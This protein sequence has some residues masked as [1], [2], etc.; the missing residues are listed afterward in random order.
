MVKNRQR[1]IGG[2][3][4]KKTH[5]YYCPECDESEDAES[6]YRKWPTVAEYD[7]IQLIQQVLDGEISITDI[8]D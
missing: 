8:F 5:E 6:C 2:R 1:T 7:A 4:D 3:I